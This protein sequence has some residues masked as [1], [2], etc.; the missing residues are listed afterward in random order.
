MAQLKLLSKCHVNDE[1]DDDLLDFRHWT[2]TAV[3]STQ[4]SF[5]CLQALLVVVESLGVSATPAEPRGCLAA[6]RRQYDGGEY[7]NICLGTGVLGLVMRL[8]EL[9]GPLVLQKIVD[10]SSEIPLYYWLTILVLSK[11]ARAFLWAHTCL[12][13]QVLGMRPVFSQKTRLVNVYSSDMSAILWA[14]IS[15]HNLWLL[16]P[17]VAAISYMLYQEIGLAAFAGMGMIALNLYLGWWISTTKSAVYKRVSKA[18]DDRMQAVKQTFG[19]IL[20]VKLHAWEQK[21]RADIQALR[22]KGC[23]LHRSMF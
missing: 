6:G 18:R 11:L 19:S 13:E 20:G 4:D 10:N 12:Q 5:A 7:E 16:L 17:Q 9:V 21:C 1:A 8:L 14:G 22:E 15:F 2:S 23:K 3:T